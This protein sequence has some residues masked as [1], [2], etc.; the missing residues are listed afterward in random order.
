MKNQIKNEHKLDNHNLKW[1]NN[2]RSKNQ[3]KTEMPIIFK[4]NGIL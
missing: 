4:L 1:K 3:I 2:I